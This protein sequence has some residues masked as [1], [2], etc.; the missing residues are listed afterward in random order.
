[1]MN[2]VEL[3]WG[4]DDADVIAYQIERI[5]AQD[6]TFLPIAHRSS[7]PQE[8]SSHAWTDASPAPGINSYRI[9][10]ES[11]NG[12]LQYS[13]IQTVQIAMAEPTLTCFPNPAHASFTLQPMQHLQ[14]PLAIHVSDLLGQAVYQV[15]WDGREPL[16][17]DAH[18]W[19]SGL[20][21]VAA[22]A[23]KYTWR[24]R[25]VID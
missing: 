8:G 22:K 20:Y 17:I 7:I 9:A 12:T 1:M 21:I 11:R 4:M 10:A 2:I 18:D 14:E 3:H 24:Q 25:L 6:P 19:P 15:N 5:R 13:E 16:Q 23:G